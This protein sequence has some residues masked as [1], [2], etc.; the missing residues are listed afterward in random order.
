MSCWCG[1]AQLPSGAPLLNS[2]SRV[3]DALVMEILVLDAALI[4]GA[5]VT[6]RW[7]RRRSAPRFASL[8][9]ALVAATAFALVRNHYGL[10][11]TAF[12]R[13]LALF[14]AL[15]AAVTA[16]ICLALTTGFRASA[17]YTVLA[18]ILV[19]TLFGTSILVR[20]SLCLITHCD[21]S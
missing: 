13:T 20:Y 8:I 7:A 6:I 3:A 5:V 9:T 14:C 10:E 21:L 18:G 12:L 11:D 1:P 16:A 4:F 2:P 17:G 15:A 19:P